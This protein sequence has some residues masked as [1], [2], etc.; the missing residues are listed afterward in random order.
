MSTLLK[1]ISYPKRPHTT[2]WAAQIRAAM[3]WFVDGASVLWVTIEKATTSPLPLNLY[4][5]ADS[6]KNLLITAHN[7]F[8]KNTIKVWYKMQAHLYIMSHISGFTP[9]WGNHRF[10]PGRGDPGFKL[11]AERGIS[12]V[13]YWSVTTIFFIALRICKELTMSRENTSF[14]T[15]KLGITF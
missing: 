15:Y 3:Y 9:I 7:P 10:S 13:M 2:Y 11:W 6:L 5:Y 4:L 12:N 14:N 1:S 8:V